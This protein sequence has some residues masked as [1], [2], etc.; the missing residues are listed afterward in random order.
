MDMGMALTRPSPFLYN[1]LAEWGKVI[2]FAA[3]MMMNEHVTYWV[4]MSDYDFDT[5]KAMLTT[6][7]YL[8]VAFMC[9]QAI[10]KMLKAYWCNVLPEPPMKIH[11]L[12]RLSERCGLDEL[13]SEAQKILSTILSR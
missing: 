8:Y 7:R 5:A 11:S 9:H 2:I 10:E 1:R 13:F 4:E 12:S 6:K 3:E